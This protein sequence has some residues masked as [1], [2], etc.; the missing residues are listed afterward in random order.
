MKELTATAPESSIAIKNK[1]IKISVSDP[2]IGGLNGDLIIG[3]GGFTWRPS[4]KS[5]KVAKREKQ[6]SWEE[7]IAFLS[8]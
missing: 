3:K 8:Q 5:T 7:V 2:A 4:P 6:K 1:G